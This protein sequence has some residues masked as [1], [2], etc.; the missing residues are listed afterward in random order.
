[1]VEGVD[2]PRDNA[3]YV[4]GRCFYE[5][6]HDY[7]RTYHREFYQIQMVFVEAY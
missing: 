1:M 5:G 6:V 4:V 7:M 3:P 2:L